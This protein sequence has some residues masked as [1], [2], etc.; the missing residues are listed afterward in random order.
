MERELQEGTCRAIDRRN[1]ETP[2]GRSTDTDR[3]ALRQ[4]ERTHQPDSVPKTGAIDCEE[5]WFP[6][7]DGLLNNETAR[8]TRTET[9]YPTETVLESEKMKELKEMRMCDALWPAHN[10]SQMCSWL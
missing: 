1:A 10:C 5:I 6:K 2:I 3:Y 8:K 4:I 7:N 9:V